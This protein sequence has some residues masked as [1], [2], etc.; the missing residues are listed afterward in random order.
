MVWT[1]QTIKRKKH[2]LPNISKYFFQVFLY[3]DIFNVKWIFLG[4]QQEQCFK[5]SLT[6]EKK[7]LLKW[8]SMKI[9]CQKL[10]VDWKIFFLINSVL[11][12]LTVLKFAFFLRCCLC[13]TCCFPAFPAYTFSLPSFSLVGGSRTK[14][15]F[16]CDR[17]VCQP[18]VFRFKHVLRM[19][20]WQTWKIMW[21]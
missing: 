1:Q 11:F 16:I 7:Q 19:H 20:A 5:W 15:F 12:C 8:T 6:C 14:I 17:T 18:Y 21:V 3:N 2:L 10:S 13:D 4:Q 9:Q